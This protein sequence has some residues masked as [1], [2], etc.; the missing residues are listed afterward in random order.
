MG[1]SDATGSSGL[2]SLPS[3]G[4]YE[5][6]AHGQAG[7]YAFNLEQTSQTSL[8]LGTPYQ[9]TFQGSGQAQ[10]FTVTVPQAGIPLLV[11]LADGTSTDQN[12]LY[13]QH[14]SADARRL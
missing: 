9:G 1:L 13:L 4:L 14:G 3:S 7:A 5:V 2:I 10:L 11:S 8:T 6:T 12:E